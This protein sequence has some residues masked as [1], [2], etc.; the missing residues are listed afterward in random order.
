MKISVNSLGIK[1]DT[2]ISIV[3]L[4][5]TCRFFHHTLLLGIWHAKRVRECSIR[6]KMDRANDIRA[7]IS[8]EVNEEAPTA[9]SRVDD[10]VN[11]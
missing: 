4:A 6:G 11:V 1:H 2:N 9:T 7:E 8:E 5:C 10:N 3:C